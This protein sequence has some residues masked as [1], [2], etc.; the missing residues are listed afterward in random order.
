MNKIIGEI[1]RKVTIVAPS[2]KCEEV[3]AIFENRPS[4]EGIL[5]CT[6]DQ[7]IGLVMR[8]NFFQKISIKYGFDLFMKRSIDLVMNQEL[9]T[10]DYSTSLSEVSSLAM[11]RKQGNLYDHIIVLQQGRL[12]GVVSI[13]ELIMKLS[14]LQINIARYSNPLSGLPGNHMIDVKLQEY[15]SFQE[16]TVFYIDIDS[17]KAFNDTYGFKEG[18]NLI[19]E[20]ANIINHTIMSTPDDPSFVGHIGGDDFIAVIPHYHHEDLCNLIISRFDEAVLRFY[21]EEDLR[22]GYVR[23]AN[24]NGVIENIPLV[25]LSIAVIQNRNIS[26]QTVEDLSKLAANVKKVCKAR[27]GSVYVT[28]GE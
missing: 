22:N 9:F 15:L 28:L 2:I 10:V 1:A 13:R 4:L 25:S 3:Y 26:I 21:S 6:N 17:F 19:K 27:N 8:T 7:P 20:T 5:V 12:F 18:D 23:T 24:R 14:E 16:Y 11:N